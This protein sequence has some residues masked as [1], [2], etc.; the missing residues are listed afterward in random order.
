MDC[1]RFRGLALRVRPAAAS[2]SPAARFEP[3]GSH[4]QSHTTIIKKAR[5]GRAFL[6]MAEGVSMG[7][8]H[9]KDSQRA[10]NKHKKPAKPCR[11]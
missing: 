6:M 8:H 5:A 3:L 1:A 11:Y 7:G 10:A 9:S 4:P 2:S